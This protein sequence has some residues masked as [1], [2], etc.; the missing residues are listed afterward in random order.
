MNHIAPTVSN[1]D[2]PDQ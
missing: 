1:T 2:R